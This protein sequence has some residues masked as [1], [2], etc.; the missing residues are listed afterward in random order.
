MTEAI[1]LIATGGTIDEIGQDKDG[2]SIFSD[3]FVPEMLNQGRVTSAVVS[4]VLMLK[5]SRD[6]TDKDRE[7]MLQ[8]CVACPERRILITHG[9]FTMPDTARYLGSPFS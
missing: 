5:D 7:A 6:V 9:T 4:E 1:R 8:R 3:S 2:K